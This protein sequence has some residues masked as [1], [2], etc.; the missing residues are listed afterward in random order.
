MLA[1]FASLIQAALTWLSQWISL[2]TPEFR[3]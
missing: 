3:P 1:F 2:S